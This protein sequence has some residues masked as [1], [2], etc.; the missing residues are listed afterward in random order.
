MDS[1]EEM[2]TQGNSPSRLKQEQIENMN[3]P[4]T[5]SDIEI[6]IKNVP[7]QKSSTRW[8]HSEFCQ[9][10]REELMPHLSENYPEVAEERIYPRHLC[11]ATITLITKA[12]Q[13]YHK[14]KIAGYISKHRH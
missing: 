2:G 10:F 5:S 9:A 13:R 12:R 11:G 7:K 6:V 8:L 1:L 14:K 3:R 4:I